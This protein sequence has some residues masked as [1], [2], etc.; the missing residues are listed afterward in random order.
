MKK[1]QYIFG[2]IAL[3]AFPL[4]AQAQ[5]QAN[6]STVNRTVVVEQEYNPD[7]LDASKVN[8]LPKVEPP[9]VNKRTVEYD[10][11]LMPAGN[12]PATVMQAYTGKEAQARALPGYVRLGY[13]NYGNLDVRANY[14]FTLSERDR[15]NLTLHMNGMDGKLDLPENAGKWN[16]YYYHT[17][18]GMDYTHG[19]GKVD[20]NVAGH[21]GLS[22]FNFLP[23]SFNSKQKFTSGDLHFGVRSTDEGPPFQFRAETNLLLYGRQH[24]LALN[25]TKET[26]VRTKAEASGAISEEQHI[27]VSLEMNNAF[28]QNNQFEDY[29]AVD[30]N[31]YYLLEN[32]DWKVRLGA[33]VDLAFDYGKKFY[34]SP[35]VMVQY[36]F[37]DSYQLYA[38]AKGGKQ[39]NDFRRLETIS[40]Y[41]QLE[42][43][44]DATYEQLNA[45]LGF[46]ASP[47]PGVW[48]NLYGGY[49]NLRNDL[50]QLA[51]VGTAGNPALLL[52]TAH[53][54]NIYAGA[55]VRYDYKD[56]LSF[57]ASGVYR[58]WNISHED[59]QKALLYFKPSLEADFR[60]DF[61]PI[62]T[63]LV[64]LGYQ[65][66]SREKV[67]GEKAD[68]VSNLY[69][70]G[71]YELFKGIS[72][73]ARVNNLLNKDY[74]Y[75]WGYPAEGINFL[76]GVSFKF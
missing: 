6:D 13:G 69:L 72:V 34:A 41:G 75:Y 52:E 50:L 39:L 18:A 62:S 74:Q 70:G 33:H 7:I 26:L 68:A 59:T 58:D 49:Q 55:E 14:L 30:L 61:K 20:L 44:P 45:A 43:Q 36:T 57:S 25:D 53:T 46:K 29:T 73:Y 23:G 38:Q 60:I 1:I 5:K 40:P 47:A 64:S 66:I 21:F 19:F 4:G 56:L 27:G 24:E 31:P 48:F 15:L 10:A 8:V 63:V 16:S 71:S 54:H 28:Y 51:I 35:D 3:L 17:F 37:A 32:D 9:T 65:N 11:T 76:G 12:I 67:E 2:G 42:L 22:N